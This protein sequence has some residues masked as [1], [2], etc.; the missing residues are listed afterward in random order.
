VIN[1]HILLREGY[2]PIN[3][4]FADRTRYYQAFKEY[5]EKKTQ[6]TME[7]IVGRALTESYHKRLAYMEGRNIVTLKEYSKT[8]KDSYSNLLNKAERQTIEAFQE[9]GVWKISAN[10]TA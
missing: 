5:D 9:K 1:N 8:N 2:V 7:E 6:K 4:A 3:I 10:Y